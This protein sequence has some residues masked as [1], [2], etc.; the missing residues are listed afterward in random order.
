MGSSSGSIVAAK[1]FERQPDRFAKVA[2]HESPLTTVLDDDGETKKMSG[3]LVQEALNGHFEAISDLFVNTMHIQPLDAQMMGLAADS[4]PDPAKMQAMRF[5]LEYESAQYTGQV[6]DWHIF[7][8]HRD[9]VILLNGTD[10]V[11]FCRKQSIKPSAK[12]SV[13]PSHRFLGVI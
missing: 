10:S 6:I 3:A 1:A 4:K 9:Q 12:K 13:F 11:G 7:A 2:I 8:Q 5:W